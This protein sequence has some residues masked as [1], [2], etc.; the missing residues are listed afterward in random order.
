MAHGI[1]KCPVPEIERT[2]TPVFG[3]NAER[4]RHLFHNCT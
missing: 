3:G 1:V 2:I 4:D